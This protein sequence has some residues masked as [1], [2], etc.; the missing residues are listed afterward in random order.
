MENKRKEEF[1]KEKESEKVK[2]IFEEFLSSDEYGLDEKE[3]E[4]EANYIKHRWENDN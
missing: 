1:Q 2:K 4:E 3:A